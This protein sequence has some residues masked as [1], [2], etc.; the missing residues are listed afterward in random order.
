MRVD[1]ADFNLHLMQHSSRDRNPSRLLRL[2][3]SQGGT[4]PEGDLANQRPDSLKYN[5]PLAF[6]LPDIV[7]LVLF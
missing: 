5:Q 7:A 3:F 1:C 4:R 6:C 2:F